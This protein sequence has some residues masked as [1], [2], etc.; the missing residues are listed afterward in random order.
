M[1]LGVHVRARAPCREAIQ[2][3]VRYSGLADA[4]TLRS[5]AFGGDLFGKGEVDCVVKV[6]GVGRVY[7]CE[8]LNGECDNKS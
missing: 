4:G 1:A 6:N 3:L 2:K 8:F 5:I 7:L